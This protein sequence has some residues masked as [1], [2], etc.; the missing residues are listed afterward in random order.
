[1]YMRIRG[2]ACVCLR[3]R[4]RVYMRERVCACNCAFN[5]ASKVI[6]NEQKH[7]S[8]TYNAA[9]KKKD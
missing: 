9:L 1:M 5:A 4:E 6:G 2:Y 7:L 8:S 3:V